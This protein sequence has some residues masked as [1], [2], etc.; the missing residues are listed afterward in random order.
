M[1]KVLEPAVPCTKG[2]IPVPMAR[3][4]RRSKDELVHEMPV[5]RAR[6]LGGRLEL[7]GRAGLGQRVTRRLPLRRIPDG[8]GLQGHEDR[9]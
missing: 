2:T 1:P 8:H 5:H 7:E 9:T 3:V 4:V 6:L